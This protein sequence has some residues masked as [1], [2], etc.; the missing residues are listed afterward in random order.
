MVD[1]QLATTLLA[2]NILR[3][4]APALTGIIMLVALRFNP[5]EKHYKDIEE[6]KKLM[7]AKERGEL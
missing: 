7:E 2:I 5:V 6:M 4:G 1:H 3:F